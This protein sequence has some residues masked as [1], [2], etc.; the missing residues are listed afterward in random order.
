MHP[1]VIYHPS[2]GKS[3]HSPAGALKD[4]TLRMDVDE[5][6]RANLRRLMAERGDNPAAL[7]LRAGLNRRAVQ[8]ILE[9]RAASPKV[10]TVFRLAE[11]LGCPASD[12]LGLAPSD[13]SPALLELL[14]QYPPE[15]QEQLAAAIQALPAKPGPERR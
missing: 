3:S 8:D 6:L 12:L 1:S 4:R 11:A 5:L 13:L 15:A 2:Q 10:S 7:S 14:R 9:G